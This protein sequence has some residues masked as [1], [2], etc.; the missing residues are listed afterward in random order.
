MN[1]RNSS[2]FDSTVKP[3]KIWSQCT[4]ALGTISCLVYAHYI[5]CS[6]PAIGLVQRAHGQVDFPE[7]QMVIFFIFFLIAGV[8]PLAHY[9][10]D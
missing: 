6:A 7:I 8:T 1:K 4:A 3:V 5:M 10:I 9:C 2:L